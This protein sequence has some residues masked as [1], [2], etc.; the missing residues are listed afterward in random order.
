MSSLPLEG[1]RVADFT[2]A[3]SGPYCSLLLADL[4]A[5]VIKVERP[6]GGDDSRGWGPPFVGDTA[7]YF[8]S[9]NRNKRSVALDLKSER[10][11]ADALR[12][13]ESCDVVV[14]NWTPGTAARLGLSYADVSAVRPG[15]VY[16][17]I[18]GYGS[19]SPDPGYDQ[20]V[21]GT[22]GWMSMTGRPNGE[23]TKI[24]VPVGDVA[25]G[26]FAANAVTA[27]LLRRERT[28]VG[29]QID[30]SMQDSLLSML[31]YHAGAFLATGTSPTRNGNEHST[32][33][34]YGTL[35]T[36]DGEIN[37]AVGNDRQWGRLCAE[38]DCPELAVDPRFADNASRS[39]NRLELYTE[40]GDVLRRHTSEQVLD[41]ARRAG[42][43]AGPINDLA[44]AFADPRV[45]ERG[46][47]LEAEHPR[48]GV[49]RS[50]GSAWHIDG[51][52]GAVRRPPPDLGEHT[53]EVFDELA[54]TAAPR[55]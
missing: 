18:S 25:S 37:L 50:A 14:E 43:P 12:L 5:D 54:A 7:T 42:V 47:V 36:G 26:M 1:V 48:L 29:A 9:I 2:Q 41:A 6:D 49:V 11:R 23:A 51:G 46:M 28:G 45:R 22:S 33:A 21:Q 10:G 19:G 38:L 3:L 8:L 31:A 17:S 30:I 40:F 4:G 27:A 24:G 53:Q 35:E 15:V 44:A 55:R 20:V 34:P 32:V 16:C 39:E 52:T 13:I